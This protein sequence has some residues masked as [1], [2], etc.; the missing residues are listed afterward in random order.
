MYVPVKVLLVS[1][2]N[3]LA[4]HLHG[5]YNNIVLCWGVV[6]FFYKEARQ[7]WQKVPSNKRLIIVMGFKLLVVIVETLLQTKF[8]RSGISSLFLQV[9]FFPKLFVMNYSRL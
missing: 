3:S 2:R 6:Q 5:K 1:T 8:V 4:D 9:N 7:V